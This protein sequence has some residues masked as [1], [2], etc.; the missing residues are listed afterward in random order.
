MFDI[1]PENVT[2]TT[3][4]LLFNIWQELSEIKALL[5]P[6][7]EEIGEETADLDGL[8]R[9]EILALVKALPDEEKPPRWSQLPSDALVALLKKEGGIIGT[10][11]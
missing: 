9:A 10:E 7:A 1:K 11:E 2:G 5:S 6:T 8:K 4:K 3:N